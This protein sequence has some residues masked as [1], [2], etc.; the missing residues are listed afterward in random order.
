MSDSETERVNDFF[1][2][3]SSVKIDCNP[4][5]IRFPTTYVPPE[6]GNPSPNAVAP[7]APPTLGM[8]ISILMLICQSSGTLAIVG[9]A[10]MSNV[11]DS[12][13]DMLTIGTSIVPNA[14]ESI[15]WPSDMGFTAPVNA[16]SVNALTMYA[17][18]G[19][20]YPVWPMIPVVYHPMV[21]Y[22]PHAHLQY[23]LAHPQVQ[24]A[25]PPPAYASPLPASASI[26]SAPSATRRIS[27]PDIG[28]NAGSQ[29]ARLDVIPALA[30][31]QPK[32]DGDDD[33]D[34][35]DASMSE[36][37]DDHSVTVSTCSSSDL[38]ALGSDEFPS[39]FDERGGRLWVPWPSPSSLPSPNS[40]S[41]S[42][43]S[44]FHSH[45]IALHQTDAVT[46]QVRDRYPLPVDGPEQMVRL[47]LSLYLLVEGG[48]L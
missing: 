8:F 4:N 21:Y 43:S 42:D 34:D 39:Y 32:E 16:S 2:Y 37:E 33:D 45:G 18:Y 41:R 7:S 31:C 1:P 35:T 40:N 3:P 29:H 25:S 36:D 20:H 12:E 23:A 19:Y 46:P 26:A 10:P 48:G 22:H 27:S 28:S 11:T 24:P 44:L 38:I 14:P 47:Y 9:R 13:L 6:F 5:E 15:G 17:P 30:T